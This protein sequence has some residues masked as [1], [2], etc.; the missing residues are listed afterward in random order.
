[1]RGEKRDQNLSAFSDWVIGDSSVST[2][3][4]E[5]QKNREGGGSDLLMYTVC[6]CMCACVCVFV[7]VCVCVFARERE[8]SLITLII[9]SNYLQTA[10]E[11]LRNL[12][13]LCMCSHHHPFC[14][15]AINLLI[16]KYN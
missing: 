11:F 5:L 4:K 9:S 16:N 7:S 3:Y 6:C 8:S 12:I 14:T 2:F 15:A 13:M 1:M 10:N